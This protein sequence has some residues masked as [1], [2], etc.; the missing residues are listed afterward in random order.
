MKASFMVN[1][2]ICLMCS[3]IGWLSIYTKIGT[4]IN[5]K[6]LKKNRNQTSE[7]V[8]RSLFNSNKCRLTATGN[9]HQNART[10][11][12]CVHIFEA[13]TE[14][15]NENSYFNPVYSCFEQT[16]PFVWSK[17]RR[18]HLIHVSF[19]RA[20]CHHDA[21][22]LFI[23]LLEATIAKQPSVWLL[24]Y[25]LPNSVSTSPLFLSIYQQEN[26]IFLLDFFWI[27]FPLVA[28]NKAEPFSGNVCAMDN[29]RTIESAQK[30][31]FSR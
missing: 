2:F 15:H 14:T 11:F 9:A 8:K 13:K 29:S 23:F 16:K 24:F 10:I 12:W 5:R 19:V 31:F 7:N 30:S 17:E 18:C 27:L 6:Q 4:N 28:N 26:S 3:L 25:C 20:I 22:G 21:A 1:T